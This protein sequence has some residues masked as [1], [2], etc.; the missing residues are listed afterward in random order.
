MLF[1]VTTI[2]SSCNSENQ[3]S[4]IKLENTIDSVS[5]AIG[6]NLGS[7][8]LRQIENAGDTNLNY[9]GII[10]GF[11]QGIRSEDLLMDEAQGTAIINKYMSDKDA[12]RRE[13]EKATF[14]INVDTEEAFFAEN[15]GKEGVFETESGLQFLVVVKGDGVLPMDGDRIRVNYEGALLDGQVFDSS[16]ERGEPAVFDINRVI[17]GWTEG[18]KL[19]PVGSKYVF[20]VPSELAYGENPPPGTIIEPYSTLVFT[21]E[22]L[23]IEK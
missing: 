21:V 1:A 19:M 9:N 16:Y 7:N 14:A 8:I 22:L 12:E 6:I 4:E 23:G 18:L 13:A 15:A 17:P 20:Y 5:Y 10:A 3:S 2:F 11:N